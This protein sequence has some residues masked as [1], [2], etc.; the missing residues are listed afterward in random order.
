MVDCNM[1]PLSSQ[2]IAIMTTEHYNLQ[3]ERSMTIAG[4]NGRASLFLG[5]VSTSLVTLAF[6]GGISRVGAGL[7]QGFYVFVLVLFPAL[8]FLGLVTFKRVL[9]SAVED[10]VYARGVNRIRHLYQE[11]ALQMRPYF[12]LLAHD[13]EASVMASFALHPTWAQT[14]ISTAG[15]I[16][17]ITSILLGGF[18]GVLLAS[19]FSLPLGVAVGGGIVTFLASGWILQR[20]LWKE[21]RRRTA[22]LHALFPAQADAR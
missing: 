12:V 8:V 21:W 17:V 7:G 1:R 19:L 11:Y 18:V 14:F 2:E 5:T 13:D 15:T 16:A 6:V 4:A 22:S 3:S 10:I 20:Y 9:Q